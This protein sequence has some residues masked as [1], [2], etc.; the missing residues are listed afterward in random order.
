MDETI[1]KMK[2][3]SPSGRMGPI[4]DRGQ[5]KNFFFFEKTKQKK[6]CLGSQGASAGPVESL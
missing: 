2:D 1:F 3:F 6:P 5:K 4:E